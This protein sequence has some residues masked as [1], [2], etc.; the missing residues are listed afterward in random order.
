ML[1]AS[2]NLHK[3]YYDAAE[4]L[5]RIQEK[6]HQIPE[7]LGTSFI[8]VE[9]YQHKHDIFAQDI[10]AIGSQVKL[11]SNITSGKI[12]VVILYELEKFRVYCY[13]RH[14]SIFEQ[15]FC[16]AISIQKNWFYP[17]RAG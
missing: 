1:R 4:T 6:R 7:D 14:S 13:N 17:V 3:Y 2:Y 10:K 9:D 12:I 5:A 11:C 8:S 15:L 16:D